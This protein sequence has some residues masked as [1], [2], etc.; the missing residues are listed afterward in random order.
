M[1]FDA[2]KERWNAWKGSET[3]KSI[4]GKTSEF[5][6]GGSLLGIN[7]NLFSRV[8]ENDRQAASAMLLYA[9]QPFMAAPVQEYTSGGD[10]PDDI[11][12][13]IS[14]YHTGNE[15]VDDAWRKMFEVKDYTNTKQGSFQVVDITSAL[16]F[17]YIPGG[18]KVEVYTLKGAGS[19]APFDLFGGALGWDKT[20]FEDQDYMKI[21][22][23]TKHFRNKYYN[24]MARAHY[25][26]ID[27]LP[28]SIDQAWVQ[29]PGQ[30]P[31][32]DPFY[33]SVRDIRTINTA[34]GN[35]I[36][37]LEAKN[38]DIDVEEEFVILAPTELQQRIGSA[39][40]TNYRVPGIGS[41]I[42]VNYNAIPFYTKLLE[43]TDVYYVV[44]PKRKIQTGIRKDLEI[45]LDQDILANSQVA[46]GWG[47]FGALI[48]E[49]DQFRRCS[50]SGGIDTVD[51]EPQFTQAIEYDASGNA[52]Y[53]GE[54]EPGTAK[55]ADDWRIRKLTYDGSGN[56]LDVQ[57]ASSNHNFDKVW[58]SRI[59]YVYG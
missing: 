30:V 41:P 20:W 24:D 50:T 40:S 25:T 26:L 9:L 58:D 35:I 8:A 53:I 4:V 29:S 1:T 14:K 18:D 48:G 52:I 5:T 36:T 10:F 51:G 2:A 19:T 27:A 47:R 59:S 22:E 38:I 23:V 37:A 57:W 39:L 3:G 28:A 21:A 17:R 32:S 34:C 43:E 11:I 6:E 42:R 45:I 13:L 12:N 46:A 7:W 33:E 15:A 16:T 54:A 55:S 44:L 49:E 31:Y 56:V